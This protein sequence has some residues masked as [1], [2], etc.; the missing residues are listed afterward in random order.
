MTEKIRCNIFPNIGTGN[1]WAKEIEERNLKIQGS[2]RVCEDIK[3]SK[4]LSL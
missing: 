4:M 2:F 1:E 3:M